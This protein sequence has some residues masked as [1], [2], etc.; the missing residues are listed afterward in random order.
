MG[1]VLAAILVLLAFEGIDAHGKLVNPMNRGTLGGY[2]YDNQNFCGGYW[3]QHV[4]G[5]KCGVCG[6]NYK[7]QVPR[8]Q[9]NGGRYGRG[10]IVQTYKSGENISVT[11]DLSAN[12]DGYFQFAVCPLDDQAETEE[13]FEAHPL[14]LAKDGSDKYYVGKKSGRLDIDLTLPKN[15]KCQQCSLRW[16]YHTANM[17]GMCENGR[18]QMGCGP[19][20]NYR[21][22]SDV[23]IV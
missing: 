7:D 4:N 18:G 10:K 13:C 12:H 16:H 19:Q 8:A 14:L 2:L 15:L 11:V 23:A 6:D 17:W 5:G 20:E 9:E 1:L 22:C 3:I 21:T